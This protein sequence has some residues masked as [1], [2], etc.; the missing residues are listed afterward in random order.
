VPQGALVMLPLT[1][2]EQAR[3][4][5][6]L[7]PAKLEAAD[8]PPT[9]ML[10]AAHLVPDWVRVAPVLAMLVG[11]YLAWLFYIRRPDF[12]GRLAAQHRPLYLF[13]LNKWYF[14]ELFDW[15]IVRPLLWL[16]RFFWRKGDGEVIDG[17]LNGVALGIIPFFARLAGRAQSGY[18]FHYA[19]AMV[20]G[21][22]ILVTWMTIFG[23]AQ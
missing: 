9:T 8:H 16:G 19:F 6:R 10:G 23:G 1:P 4:A 14:D 5:D 13:L 17:A 18:L 15:V 21:I 11:L 20:L 22:V 2:E 7:D 12:P 3:I